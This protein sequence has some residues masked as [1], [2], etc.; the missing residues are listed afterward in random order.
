[1]ALTAIGTALVQLYQ[2][3]EAFRN[4]VNSAWD[5][6]KSKV[7]ELSSAFMNFAGPAIDAVVAGFNRLKMAITSA[8]SG[9]FSQ[10]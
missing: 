2:H 5:S 3:N 8:F 4:G 6:I 7:T 9:D 1:M 10:L